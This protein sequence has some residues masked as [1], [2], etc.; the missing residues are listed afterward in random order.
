MS[1]SKHLF[2]SM[3]SIISNLQNLRE[4][5]SLSGEWQYNPIT[6]TFLIGYA[7]WMTTV[8]SPARTSGCKS[9][10]LT[11]AINLFV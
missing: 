1:L 6:V 8:I 9:G 11:V 2:V 4:I 10:P 7:A 3:S 5:K